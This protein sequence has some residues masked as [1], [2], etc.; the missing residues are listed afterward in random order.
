VLIPDC[1][2]SA[3]V[4]DEFM[5]GSDE[6]I[7]GQL[8]IEGT[9]IITSAPATSVALAPAGAAHTAFTGVLLDLLRDGIP[10]GPELLSLATVY[11]HPLGIAAARRLPR[12]S[13]RGTGTADQLALTRNPSGH[14][15]RTG[16]DAAPRPV[17]APAS[18]S[19]GATSDDGLRARIHRFKPS[20]GQAVLLAVT[21]AT[22]LL[23]IDRYQHETGSQKDNLAFFIVMAVLFAF[24]NAVGLI[25]VLV[26]AFRPHYLLVEAD[27][28]EV[29]FAGRRTRYRWTEL[30]QVEIRRT[31][32]QPVRAVIRLE[33]P[34][35]RGVV[36]TCRRLAQADSCPGVG[37]SGV[38]GGFVLVRGPAVA[39]SRR[40]IPRLVNISVWA[41]AGC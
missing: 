19:S 27:G 22:T 28:I 18:R 15:D 21:V 30:R 9:Y 16:A 35:F 34:R 37:L 26:R 3:R 23:L 33:V 1:C 10:D 8:D 29:A 11:R 6:A 24:V 4:T 25:L 32:V 13:Q 5:S 36:V 12:P 41:N 17:T 39:G 31:R 38:P 2:F 20:A 7:L 40:S 14:P